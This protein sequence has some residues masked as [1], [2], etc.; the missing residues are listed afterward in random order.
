M[1]KKI[2]GTHTDSNV[3][4]AK[5]KQELA[6]EFK[7]NLPQTDFTDLPI[8]VRLHNE[9]MYKVLLKELEQ[10]GASHL[11]GLDKFALIELSNTLHHL[12]RFENMLVDEELDLTQEIKILQQRNTLTQTVDRQMKKLMLDPASRRELIEVVNNDISNIKLDDE[13]ENFINSLMAGV[14]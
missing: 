1:N 2:I 7:K 14:N 6:E 9:L 8:G 4:R 11:I 13:D 10:L 12:N 3:T 5:Q